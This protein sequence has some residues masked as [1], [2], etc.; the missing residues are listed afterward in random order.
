VRFRYGF[1]EGSSRR[2]GHI[3][4]LLSGEY[5]IAVLA[6]SWDDRC[7][8]ITSAQRFSPKAVLLI[9]FADNDPA[10]KPKQ[11][12]NAERL[13]AYLASKGIAMAILKDVTED[14]EAEFGRLW[15]TLL[16]FVASGRARVF[17]DLSACPRY[18]TL[19]AISGLLRI[20]L[21]SQVDI[22]YSEATY[23][24]TGTSPH[25]AD[26]PFSEGR[27][28]C[29]PIPYLSGQF[30]PSKRLIHI[31][32]VGFEGGKTVRLLE[33]EE[34]THV[35]LLL[36]IPGVI[37]RYDSEVLERNKPVI[38][39]FGVPAQRILKAQAADPVAAWRTVVNSATA[40]DGSEV[41][42]LCC[43]TKAHSLGLALSA[44]STEN[45]TVMYN[46][47]EKHRFVETVASGTYWLYRIRDLSVPEGSL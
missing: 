34:A 6:G 38:S 36:P 37:E 20:G 4:E 13:R 12:A 22:L 40:P 33:K 17:V 18:Y 42:Y 15:K 47:P 41:K 2:A 39:R 5:D 25:P 30:R 19:G 8:A 16:P 23:P 44:L 28:R 45:A 9:L 1:I 43:G 24:A 10:G 21:A 32:S 29:E 27:W 31:V 46:V 11:D 7:V 26:V 35:T 3:D 14:V